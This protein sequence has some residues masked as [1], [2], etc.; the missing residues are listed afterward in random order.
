MSSPLSAKEKEIIA[1]EESLLAEVLSSLTQQLSRALERLSIESARARDL[2]AELVSYTRDEDKQMIASDEAVAHGLRDRKAAEVAVLEKLIK[3]P[4]F[5]RLVLEEDMSDGIKQLEYRMGFAENSECRIIDWRKAPV[6]KLYYEYKTGDEYS[7]EIL[8]RER[9]GTIRARVQVEIEKSRLLRV[10]CADGVFEL[11]AGA[12]VKRSEPLRSR[13]GL[14]AE[15]NG[16]RTNGDSTNGDSGS[17][18]LPEIASMLTPEQFQLVA[19]SGDAALM[20]QGIAGSGKTTVALH[21]L[22]WMLGK[23]P[24]VDGETLSTERCAVVVASVPLRE[25]VSRTLPNLGVSGVSTT[26]LREWLGLTVARVYPALLR[27]VAEFREGTSLADRIGRPKG[28]TPLGIERVKRS[29]AMLKALERK[30]LMLSEAQRASANARNLILETLKDPAQLL[31]EDETKL[32]DKETLARAHAH[33]SQNEAAGVLDYADDALI[34]RVEQLLHGRVFFKEGKAGRYQHVVADE[35]QD[36]SPIDL[37]CIIGSVADAR[38]LT[39]IGDTNQKLDE[40]SSFA[41]WEKLRKFWAF[42]DSMSTFMSLNLSQR[43]T[44]QILK[45]ADYVQNRHGSQASQA[46]EGRVGRKPIWFKCG[47]EEDGVMSTI[48]W[49]TRGAQKYPGGLSAVVCR[50]VESARYVYQLLQP[51]F[52]P[53]L[54]LGDDQSFSFN[55]GIIVTSVNQVKGLEFTNVLLWNPSSKDYPRDDTHRNMLYTV[56]TRAEENLCIV[57]WTKPSDIL[58]SFGSPIVRGH[59]LT[60]TEP[61][62]PPERDSLRADD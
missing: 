50:S 3:K 43:S 51:T 31:P 54:R 48:D 49:I 38:G 17:R 44:L 16:D 9:L 18:H 29:L 15:N 28:G 5:A 42:K 61:E 58:P 56:I 62:N 55:E 7:E 36:Y 46:V 1:A 4:Y 22:A 30:V 24:I 25:Y 45:L 35:V 60:V 41:G 11:R 26:T 27:P 23:G 33:T 2:T 59:D 20:I 39:L 47:N 52:G 14:S 21:R 40:S 19:E 32:I 10:S 13:S 37:A 53:Q 6:A 57:S 34:V 12:W 8:G